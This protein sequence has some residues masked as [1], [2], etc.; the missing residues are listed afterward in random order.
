MS[1]LPCGGTITASRLQK[2]GLAPGSDDEIPSCALPSHPF[3]T[4]TIFALFDYGQVKRPFRSIC[5]GFD[6]RLTATC[7]RQT[8][9]AKIET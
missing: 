4:Y 6:V 3:H 8:K 1:T 5:C 7:G 9:S 2:L